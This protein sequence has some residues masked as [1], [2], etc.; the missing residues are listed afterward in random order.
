V[1][2]FERI[3]FEFER[4]RLFYKEFE[5]K[6]RKRTKEN[7]PSYLLIPAAERLIYPLPQRPVT[8][9]S[10]LFFPRMLTT[11]PRLLASPPSLSFLLL[12]PTAQPTRRRP[13]CRRCQVPSPALSLC[14]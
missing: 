10:F 4:K 12:L 13:I 2:K 8:L 5:K 9:L 14:F 1:K 6:K 11:G 3:W 7:L